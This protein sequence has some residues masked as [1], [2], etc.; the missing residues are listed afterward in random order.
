MVKSL[1]DERTPDMGLSR[2]L[3]LPP[4]KGHSQKADN[5][6]VRAQL[7]EMGDNGLAPRHVCHYFF[8]RRWPLKRCPQADIIAN[9]RELGFAAHPT[10]K[11][12]VMCDAFGPVAGDGFDRLTESLFTL[13]CDNGWIYD[14]WECQVLGLGQTTT[15]TPPTKPDETAHKDVEAARRQSAA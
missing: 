14:G 11:K 4:P 10:D 5:E 2:M 13:G 12:G 15:A 1:Q 7:A 6:R 8:A 9:L 3:R